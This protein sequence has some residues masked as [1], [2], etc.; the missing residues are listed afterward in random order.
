LSGEVEAQAKGLEPTFT[1]DTNCIYDVE[2]VRSNAAAIAALVARH[3]AGTAKVAVVAISA[4]ELQPG[5][6]RLENFTEFQD[7]LKRLGLSDLEVLKP[8]GFWGVSYWDQALWSA[9]PAET[10]ART[11]HGIL[12]P[13]AFFTLDECVAAAADTD[14]AKRDWINRHCD[15]QAIWSHIY[16][17][18]DVF[19]TGDENFHKESK[20]PSLIALGAKNV[21]RP[22]DAAEYSA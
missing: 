22:K 7:R 14:K 9:E 5:G 3:R 19:V 11:I 12:F 6:K 10:L 16:A 1:L 4:S 15:Q 17:G 20:K 8:L 18:R 13:G 21:L 2:E